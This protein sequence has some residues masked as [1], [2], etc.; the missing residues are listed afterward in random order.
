MASF[1]QHAKDCERFLGDRCEAVNLWIDEYFK[2]QGP[3]HRKVRHHWEGIREAGAKFGELAYYGAVVH[4]LRDCR[5]IP[6]REDY[7]TG[8]ADPLGLLKSWPTEA[9]IKYEDQD[10]ETLVMNNILG[11]TGVALWAFIDPGTLPQFLL[12]LSR[13]TPPEIEQLLSKQPEAF[14]AAKALPPL[15]PASLP[16]RHVSQKLSDYLETW[17]P[18]ITNMRQAFPRAELAYVSVKDLVS[19]L[20]YVDH[21]YLDE[22]RP[23]LASLD[24]V[25]VA[26][27][28]LP[29]MINMPVRASIDPTL[30]SVHFVSSNRTMT[31]GPAQVVSAEGGVEVRF[32]VGAHSSAIT[33]TKIR[34]RLILQTGIHRAYLLAKLGVTEIPCILKPEEGFQSF[35]V[36]AYP[37]FVPQTLLQPRPPILLDYLDDKLGVQIPLQRTR[38]VIRVSAEE[39]I[40]PI[41]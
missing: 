9:Y 38:R 16:S 25:D 14:A 17:A 10:F 3:Y 24:E 28:A 1:E 2:T 11:S 30:R 26:R 31:V 23:E 4:V 37:V 7:E 34:D 32:F 21:E 18:L 15:A 19:P 33:V 8:R 41:D 6:N 35:A 29:Q 39:S 36:T 20:V 5:N 13:L 27:F 12:G 40:L 22:L